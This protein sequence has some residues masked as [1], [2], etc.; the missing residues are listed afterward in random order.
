MVTGI[1]GINDNLTI[2]G[3]P[4]GKCFHRTSN[5][6]GSAVAVCG[7]DAI[8]IDTLDPYLLPMLEGEKI[9]IIER[10]LP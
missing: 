8:Y 7:A 6:P 3:E 2:L 10:F 5:S 1:T 9:D 4:E